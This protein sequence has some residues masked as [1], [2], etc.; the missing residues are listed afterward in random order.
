MGISPRPCRR[1]I[2]KETFRFFLLFT[3]HSSCV[4]FTVRVSSLSISPLILLKLP[5]RQLDPS[6]RQRSKWRETARGTNFWHANDSANSFRQ[7]FECRGTVLSRRAIAW[8]NLL[9]ASRRSGPLSTNPL[10]ASL[11]PSSVSSLKSNDAPRKKYIKFTLFIPVGIAS[12]APVSHLFV[13]TVRRGRRNGFTALRLLRRGEPCEPVATV[14]ITRTAK[15]TKRRRPNGRPSI[16]L[17]CCAGG[18]APKT[19]LR[20]ITATFSGAR[21]TRSPAHHPLRHKYVT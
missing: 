2:Q 8:E 5:S 13:F 9:R 17:K 10:E 15:R 21:L 11:Q 19:R 20:P 14:S 16:R 3:S 6:V 1:Q 4:Q 18:R 7:G 12:T